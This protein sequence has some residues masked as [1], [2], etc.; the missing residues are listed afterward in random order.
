ML[1]KVEMSMTPSST[2]SAKEYSNIGK[3]LI[4]D[5]KLSEPEAEK[6]ITNIRDGT[7]NSKIKELV[8]KTLTSKSG[9]SKQEAHAIIARIEKYLKNSEQMGGKKRHSKRNK[10]QRRK[11]RR[12]TRS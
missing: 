4:N 1:R 10:K 9:K 7:A 3:S 8:N 2:L 6:I 5:F 11:T 12:S